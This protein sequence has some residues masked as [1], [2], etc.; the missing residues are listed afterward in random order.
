MAINPTAGGGGS[1]RRQTPPSPAAAL[2]PALDPPGTPAPNHGSYQSTWNRYDIW[3]SREFSP[4]AWPHVSGV[5]SQTPYPPRQCEWANLSDQ[6]DPNRSDI[7]S[8]LRT[9]HVLLGTRFENYETALDC[10]RRLKRAL[11]LFA[12]ERRIGLDAGQDEAAASCS[13][14]IKDSLATQHAI[15]APGRCSRTGCLH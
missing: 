14:A 15:R 6:S 4:A 8:V 7:A 12:A 2:W 3:L 5:T 13:Q 9:E 1:R 10:G 11:A